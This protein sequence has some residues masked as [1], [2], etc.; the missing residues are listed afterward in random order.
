[1]IDI[2]K[3]IVGACIL[4]AGVFAI[5]FLIAFLF[6]VLIFLIVVGVIW[7]ILKLVQMESTD[8]PPD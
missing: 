8:I 4:I 6:P 7:F 1:L 5:S 3:S 2:L